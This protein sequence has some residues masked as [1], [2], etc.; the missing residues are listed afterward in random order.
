MH[1]AA[2]AAAV[3]FDV[4]AMVD[5]HL[6]A[7]SSSLKMWLM[8]D[9]DMGPAAGAAAH[10]SSLAP[11]AER[12]LKRKMYQWA[13]LCSKVGLEAQV[14]LCFEEIIKNLDLQD[15]EVHA[16]LPKLKESDAANL[17]EAMQGQL[18]V[19]RQAKRKIDELESQLDDLRRKAARP[20]EDRVRLCATCRKPWFYKPDSRD[21]VHYCLYCGSRDVQN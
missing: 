9:R 4:S 17:R 2:A 18:N 19:A 11:E 6:P 13:A 7:D 14:Q 21:L 3:V 15:S 16:L 12:A 1:A 8:R 20:V 5:S 10:G